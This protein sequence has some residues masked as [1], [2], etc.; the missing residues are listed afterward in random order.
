MDL[1][2]IDVKV[3]DEDLTIKLLCPLSM[4]YKYFRDAVMY[5]QE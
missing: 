4:Q 1:K 3:D 5:N 2:N